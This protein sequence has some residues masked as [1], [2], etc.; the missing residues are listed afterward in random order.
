MHFGFVIDMASQNRYKEHAYSDSWRIIMR[1]LLLFLIFILVIT[2]ITPAQIRKRN[3]QAPNS[4]VGTT[5][6]IEEYIVKWKKAEMSPVTFLA[7]GKTKTANGLSMVWKQ[8]GND[9]YIKDTDLG[10]PEIWAKLKGNQ[11]TGSARLG[12]G[13]QE[14]GWRAQRILNNSVNKTR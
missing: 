9:I 14:S 6:K 7:G 4:L 2:S 12:Q 11:M 10:W 13:G 8:T 5:W 3:S 1:K